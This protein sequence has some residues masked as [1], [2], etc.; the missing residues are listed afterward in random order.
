MQYPV[1]YSAWAVLYALT[2]AL[3]FAEAGS[4]FEE[5]VKVALGLAFFVPGALVLYKARREKNAHHVRLVRNLSIASLSLT[6]VLLV[7]NVLSVSWSEA[8]GQALHGALALCSAPM[9]CCGSWAVSLFL[10]ACLLMATLKKE[11]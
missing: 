7:L 4:G 2:A 3:G 5:A 11:K 1:L 8:V 6:A 10:W 9:L